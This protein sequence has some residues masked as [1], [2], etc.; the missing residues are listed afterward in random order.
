MYLDLIKKYKDQYGFKIFSYIL[1]P[2]QLSLLLELKEETTISV[3]MH[4]L[5]SS[6]TKYY[7]SRYNRKGHLQ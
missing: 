6:Y 7:N 3:I 2:N 5:T 1:M 4:D